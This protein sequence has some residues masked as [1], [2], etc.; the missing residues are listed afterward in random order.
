MAK[1][2]L[3]GKPDDVTLATTANLLGLPVGAK[4]IVVTES[5]VPVYLVPNV[6]DGA[7]L[8][9]TAYHDLGTVT[10]GQPVEFDI[11]TYGAVA[12]ASS[13]SG[14]ARVEVR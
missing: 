7:S 13:G 4:T 14:T 8:P 11:A 5:D 3:R 9:S 6:A 1:T 10:A 12:L 2:L